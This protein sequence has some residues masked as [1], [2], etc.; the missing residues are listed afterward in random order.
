MEPGFNNSRLPL[1]RAIPG[2]PGSRGYNL[3]G[4]G[5]QPSNSTPPMPTPF[6][7][8]YFSNPTGA[9]DMGYFN[10]GHA[11]MSTLSH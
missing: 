3:R 6:A 2:K 7:A 1:P 11:T 5:L 4:K 10:A 9:Q 8:L